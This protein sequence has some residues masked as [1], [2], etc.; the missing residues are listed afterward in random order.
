MFLPLSAQQTIQTRIR[1]LVIHD[2]SF[3]QMALFLKAK[4]FQCPGGSHVAWV[5][6]GFQA[7]QVQRL[8]GIP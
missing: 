2:P 5:N 4:T 1:N 3:P 7:I 8:E 6:V